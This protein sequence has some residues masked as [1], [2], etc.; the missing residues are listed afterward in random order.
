M[1][2]PTSGVWPPGSGWTVEEELRIGGFGSDADDEFG[3]VGSIAVTSAGDIVVSDRHLGEVRVY[4]PQ[5]RFLRRVGQPGSGP[6]EFARG[7][8]DVLVARGDTLLV[9]DV[10]NQRIHRFGP[11][12][13]L[14][15]SAPLD[16][17]VERPMRFGASPGTRVV[18]AQLRTMAGAGAGEGTDALRI[19]E[20]SGRFGDTLLVLP[21]GG[22]FQGGGLRYF[23]PEP[24]WTLSDSATVIQGVNSA[25]ALSVHDGGGRVRRIVRKDHR[26]RPLTDRD[27]RAFFAYLDRAWL[28]AG[29][30][31]SQLPA[32]RAQVSFAEFLPA[33]AAL[34]VGPGGS[35]WV[36]P[37]QAPSDLSDAQIEAY[38]FIEDYGAADWDVFDA[39]GRYLG[40]VA[41][42]PRF[43]PRLFV[44]DRIFGVS[45]DALDVPT[46]VRLRVV[47]TDLTPRAG[48]SEAPGS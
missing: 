13:T 36:Q 19:L 35:L 21:S 6:G 33:F 5:G 7:P 29:V 12:G 37:V 9:P 31:P 15:P 1:A 3:Q 10:R 8:L 14:L 46:V 25:Y 32:N 43:Q 34:A 20:P 41:M 26:R 27:E 28:D 44:E 23:T 48:E 24:L 45:R 4:S 11:D 30:P 22:L 39:E 2:N 16:P 47:E 18:A 38:N 17:A 42:P 40:V